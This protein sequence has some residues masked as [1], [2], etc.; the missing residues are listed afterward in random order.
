MP[1]NPQTIDI[2]QERERLLSEMQD[3]ADEQADLAL[4][5]ETGVTGDY[6]A[7][8]Q[9]RGTTLEQYRDALETWDCEKVTIAGLTYG[10]S[11]FLQDFLDD[12]AG[13]KHSPA[14]IA[15]GTVDAPYMSHDPESFKRNPD[16]VKE[17]VSAVCELD[18]P[19]ARWLEEK[20]GDESG[21]GEGMGNEYTNLL[22]DSLLAKAETTESPA[23]NG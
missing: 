10:D 21:L 8:L 3:N 2:E 19:V 14:Y 18:I 23:A 22:V 1:Q 13:I 7:Q 5:D 17:T 20:I 9:N 11:L 12:N 15:I 16:G 6:L 4:Q